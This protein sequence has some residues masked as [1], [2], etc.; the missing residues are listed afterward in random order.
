MSYGGGRWMS[1][2]SYAQLMSTLHE[3]G[4]SPPPDHFCQIGNWSDDC[5]EDVSDA[6]PCKV[7]YT[8]ADCPGGAPCVDLLDVWPAATTSSAAATAAHTQVDGDFLAVAGTL[9]DGN[10]T[11]E[12]VYQLPFQGGPADPGTGSYRIEIRDPAGTLVAE[13]NYEPVLSDPDHEADAPTAE[14]ALHFLELIPAPAEVDSLTV[15]QGA[16]VLAQRSAS[17]NPPKVQV[18]SP[19]GGETWVPGEP[20]VISWSASDEDPAD[21]VSASVFLSLDAGV[22]WSPLVF[23][24]EASQFMA[25][26]DHIA[27]A[28]QALVRVAITDGL[29]SSTDESDAFFQ[30]LPKPKSVDILRPLDHGVHNTVETLRVQGQ[31]HSL[32]NG[33]EPIPLA[34]EALRFTATSIFGEPPVE[35]PGPEAELDLVSAIYNL[36]LTLI[37][38][39]SQQ[40][41]ATDLQRV[42]VSDAR[43]E[44]EPAQVL[45]NRVQITGLLWARPGEVLVGSGPAE[46]IFELDRSPAARFAV[47]I[48]QTPGANA[49]AAYRL[50][51]SG[52]F[53]ELGTLSRDDAAGAWRLDLSLPDSI[54]PPF[55]PDGSDHARVMAK[56]GDR[57]YAG[58]LLIDRDGDLTSDH[59]DN[60]P[61][62]R[63]DNQGDANFDGIGD[64]CQCGDPNGT[65]QY[66]SADLFEAFHCIK[67][68]PEAIG[69]CAP[70][71]LKGDANGTGAFES[72]DLFAIFRALTGVIPGSSLSCP[73]G[74]AAFGN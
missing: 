46:V 74:Q 59:E 35:M 73:A 2:R 56:L 40:I 32:E 17:A 60:C 1:P 12:P 20:G 24:T 72:A 50:L 42:W 14:P 69:K 11:L 51:E 71:I 36:T 3:L 18:L 62:L 47:D 25:P 34:G 9:V 45:D 63:N 52:G 64:S 33:P 19:N 38:P 10:A 26:A 30:I 39:V 27:G 41:L 7:C 28:S 13:R 23:G 4:F 70:T 16:Q 37:D 57:R 44:L 66:E 67:E 55:T 22:S 21:S 58:E 61:L 49:F 15:L 5:I 65:G 31:A 6:S 54:L 8:D 68:D 29:L 53:A 48:E 43:A